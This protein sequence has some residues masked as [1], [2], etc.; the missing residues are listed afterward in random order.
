M[1]LDNLRR[2]IALA[3]TGLLL[4]WLTPRWTQ[5]LTNTMQA[6]PL[7]SVGY[8]VLGAL[9]AMATVIGL[10]TATVLLAAAFGAT[11]LLGLMALP[12]SRGCLAQERP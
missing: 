9:V 2:L 1:V 8:G 5:R 11:T 7:P 6:R 3:F 12:S 10:V 4:L